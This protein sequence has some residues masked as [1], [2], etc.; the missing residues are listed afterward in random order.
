MQRL[1][2]AVL[3]ATHPHNLYVTARPVGLPLTHTEPAFGAL[4]DL[5]PYGRQEEWQDSPEGWGAGSGLCWAPL[6]GRQ[7]CGRHCAY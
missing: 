5:L 3:L 1:I 7:A 2:S 4:I 6:L